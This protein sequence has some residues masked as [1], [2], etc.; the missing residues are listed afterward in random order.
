MIGDAGEHLLAAQI[1]HYYGFPCRLTNIDIGID[2]EI[3]LIDQNYK[4]T[5]EII[6]AQVKTK[7]AEEFEVNV[8][9]GHIKYWNSFNLPAVIFLVHLEQGNI[10]W[11]ALD[12]SE[13]Y[14]LSKRN[15]K[16]AFDPKNKV[17]RKN[18]NEFI[19]IVHHKNERLL[20]SLYEWV[21]ETLR[22][23]ELILEDE[24]TDLTIFEELV[25]KYY[26]VC[27]LINEADKLIESTPALAWVKKKYSSKLI[28]FGYYSHNIKERIEECKIDH[29]PEIFDQLNETNNNWSINDPLN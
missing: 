2:T 14:N 21:D 6:K 20:S 24:G 13:N 15:V 18:K 1:I 11:H 19:R 4:S 3:E 29:G 7:T 26:K 28:N 27:F 8:K 10:Y 23:D 12:K 22:N 25:Y 5:G 9:S 16:I 17:G